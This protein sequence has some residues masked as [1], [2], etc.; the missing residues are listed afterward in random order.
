MEELPDQDKIELEKQRGKVTDLYDKA[1]PIYDE[2][3]EG[4]AENQITPALVGMYEKYEIKEGVILDVGCGT[5]KLK[6][7]LGDNFTYK[8]IDISP[9]MVEGAKKRGYEV[10]IGPVEEQ[11]VAFAD[12]SVDHIVA[13]SS[14]FFIKDW[15]TLAREIQR[16]ARKSIFVSLEQFEPE[17]IEKFKEQGINIYNHSASEIQDPTEIIKNTFLWKRP[18]TTE[19]VEIFGD[20]VFKKM[21]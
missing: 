8:G 14:V 12:K 15:I 10:Y 3:F 7:Y 9:L 11:I 18:T 2:L 20:L 13:V 5:G 4:K 16:V 21:S 6:E 17:L 1:A 19:R